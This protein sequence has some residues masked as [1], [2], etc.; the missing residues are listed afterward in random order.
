VAEA[1]AGA[2][3]DAAAAGA[4]EALPA[5]ALK[6]AEPGVEAWEATN[7]LCVARV[8]TAAAQRRAET[9]GCHWRE[10]HA[11]RDDTDWRRH[12]VVRLCPDRSLAVHTT[13]SA[14]FP[15]TLPQRPQEQ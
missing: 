12:L 11:D 8:L 9:R 4:P 10:D 14:D 6:P 2:A 5:V 3:M 13:D 1:A 15:P 7:L